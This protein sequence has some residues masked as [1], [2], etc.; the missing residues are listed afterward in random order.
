MLRPCT[1]SVM[2]FWMYSAKFAVSHCGPDWPMILCESSSV[3][4][5]TSARPANALRTAQLR[6]LG[7]STRL[8]SS[9]SQ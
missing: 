8:P 4:R 1:Y 2:F 9:L 3:A 7:A 6:A 5:L